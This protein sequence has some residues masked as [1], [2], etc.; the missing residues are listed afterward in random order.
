MA[1]DWRNIF[2]TWSKPTSDSEEEKA[3]RAAR[4]IKAAVYEHAPLGSKRIS[5]YGTGSYKNNTNTRGE[6]DID[7]AVVLHDCFFAAYPTDRAPQAE[8]LGHGGGVNYGLKQ[9]RADVRVALED[10]FGPTGVSPGGKAFDVHANTVRLDADVAVFLEHRQYTGNR[11]ADGTWNYFEGVEMRGRGDER[12]IN[13]HEQHHRNGVEKNVRTARHYKRVVRI[14]KRLRDDMQGNGTSES[15]AAAQ[16][17]SFLLESL[18]YNASDDCF[19]R[20]EL[21]E[22]TRSVIAQ[23]WNGTRPETKDLGLVEVSGRKWLFGTE[24]PWSKA[25]AHAFLVRAW[26]HVGFKQ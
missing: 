17:P 22:D 5:V 20:G 14:L 25:S 15:K 8:H 18:A 19:Q 6:S 24:Q 13:W 10:T 3:D 11:N 7:I 1:R 21:F 2:A 16:V 9:F 26:Q 4:M 23:L 12:I